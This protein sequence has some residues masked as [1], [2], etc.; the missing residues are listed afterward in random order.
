MPYYIGEPVTGR[1]DLFGAA[2]QLA[3][4]LSSKARARTILVASAVRDLALGKG[5]QFGANRNLRLKGFDD[6]VRSCEVVWLPV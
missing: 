2:V 1:D 5:F 6:A 3:A 4:R